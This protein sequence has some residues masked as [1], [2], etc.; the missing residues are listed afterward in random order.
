MTAAA[1]KPAPAKTYT[2]AELR[3]KPA[4]CDPAKLETY[5]SDTAFKAAFKLE[6]AQFSKLPAWKQEEFKKKLG[7]AAASSSS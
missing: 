7:L 3:A 2:L 1:A 5:L 6:K 4:E